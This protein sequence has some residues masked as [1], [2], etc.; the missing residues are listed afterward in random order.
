MGIYKIGD[1]MHK[2]KN[3]KKKIFLYISILIFIF[4]IFY[5]FINDNTSNNFI[6]R[7][8]KDLS[9]NISNITSFS[10]IKNNDNYNSELVT[11]MNKDYKK[12]INDLKETLDLTS[13]NSDKKF[14]NA[15][16]VKR[17][18]NYW[19]N[20]ITINKGKKDNIKKGYAVINKSGLIGKV[21]KVNNNTSDV[22]LLISLNDE[23]CISA[24]FQYDNEYYYGLIDKYDYKK[25]E[26]HLKNVIGDFDKEKIKNINV[27]TSGLSDLFSSGLLI[28]KIKYLKKDTFGLSN[29]LIISPAV[30]FDNIDIVTVVIGDK[31]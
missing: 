27:V 6:F 9:A 17:S 15:T 30:N 7:S 4:F 10:F 5:I 22:K 24:M 25:N 11:E 20:L 28:G 13:V 8:V 3:H 26:L 16:T 2:N 14:I 1:I 31:K 21:I 12:Q 23:N 19:Y 18:T 29:T